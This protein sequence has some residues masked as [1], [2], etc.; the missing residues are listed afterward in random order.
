MHYLFKVRW[1]MKLYS[2]FLTWRIP[3]R[4]REVFLTFDDGPNPGVT[5][6]VLYI[7]EKYKVKASFFCLGKNVEGN[8]ELFNEILKAGHVIGNHTYD[9]ADG[10]VSPNSRYS[11]SVN[12]CES[13]FG[14]QFFRPPYGK[15]TPVQIKKL[16]KRFQIVMWSL[17]SG[18][19]DEKLSPDKILE[20]LK[21]NT[22]TGDIVVFHDSIK[23]KNNLLQVLPAYL[24]FLNEKG[25]KCSVL[26]KRKRYFLFF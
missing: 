16:R 9:H 26:R 12:R 7:L 17:L 22:K 19:F 6:E 20:D 13:V 2:P 5:D 21:N 15:I 1:W 8:V 4:K 24:E 10:W 11:V 25:F 23:A 3:N 18:D 14:S